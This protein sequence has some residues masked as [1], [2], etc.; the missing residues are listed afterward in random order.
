MPQWTVSDIGSAQLFACLNQAICLMQ[1]LESRV[2]CLDCINL[3]D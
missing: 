1:G 3:G 2:L